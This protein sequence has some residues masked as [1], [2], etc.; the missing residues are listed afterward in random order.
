MLVTKEQ[1]LFLGSVALLAVVGMDKHKPSDHKSISILQ[2]V[3]EL[4]CLSLGLVN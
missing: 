1:L 2:V 3:F 4:R